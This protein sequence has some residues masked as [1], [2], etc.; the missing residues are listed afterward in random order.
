MQKEK[1]HFLGSGKFKPQ[2]YPPEPAPYPTN[3]TA[4]PLVSYI[5]KFTESDC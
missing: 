2:V 3:K 5:G 1:K 4:E